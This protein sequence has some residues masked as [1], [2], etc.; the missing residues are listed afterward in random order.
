VVQAWPFWPV[1][2]LETPLQQLSS[3][4]LILHAACV[5]LYPHYR[6][7]DGVVIAAIPTRIRCDLDVGLLAKRRRTAVETAPRGAARRDNGDGGRF[8]T[9]SHAL[10]HLW[11]RL[12]YRL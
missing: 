4:V 8:E 12:A 11:S 5:R 1:P 3:G 6:G 10:E 9:P 7:Q 2:R